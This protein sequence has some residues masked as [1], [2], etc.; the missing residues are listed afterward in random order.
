MRNRR[1]APVVRRRTSWCVALVAALLNALAPVFAYAIGQPLHELAGGR[2]GG[3]ARALLAA[4]AMHHAGM[5]ADPTQAGSGHTGH[6][7]HVHEGQ[8]HAGSAIPP[9]AAGS[10]DTPPHCPYCLDFAAGAALGSTV[11]VSVAAQPGHPPLPVITPARV[12]ARASLRLP[13]SR[14]PPLAG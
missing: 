6:A 4:H 9:S 5:P 8:V 7:G 13:A 14:G 2:P 1:L 11:P 10:Q 3:G 12:A